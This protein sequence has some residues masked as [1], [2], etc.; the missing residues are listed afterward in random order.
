[1]DYRQEFLDSMGLDLKADHFFD[2][3]LSELDIHKKI[4]EQITPNTS[5]ASKK[6]YFDIEYNF[7]FRFHNPDAIL[8]SANSLYSNTSGNIILDFPKTLPKELSLLDYGCGAAEFS[9][10]LALNGYNNITLAELPNLSFKWLQYIAKKEKLN[11]KFIEI[12]DDNELTEMYD[13]INFSEVLEHVWNPLKIMKYLIDHLKIGNYMYLSHFFNDLGGKEPFHLTHNN[14]YSDGPYFNELLNNLGLFLFKNDINGCPKIY[15]KK[16][17][18]TTF[19]AFRGI[20][21]ERIKSLLQD[22]TFRNFINDMTRVKAQGQDL[23]RFVEDFV[24]LYF[25]K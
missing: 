10:A 9:L 23:N 19:R 11:L 15:Q 1:M 20:T 3:N 7:R 2:Q 8:Q 22:D 5:E 4:S 18:Q 25:K 6:L 16:E 13:Y 14:I 21:E 17:P 12:T 24:T